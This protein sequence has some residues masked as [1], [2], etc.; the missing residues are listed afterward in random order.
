MTGTRWQG[1]IIRKISD[2]IHSFLVS[3]YSIG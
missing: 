2:W 3:G 1:E